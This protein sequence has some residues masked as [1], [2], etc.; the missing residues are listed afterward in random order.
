MPLPPCGHAIAVCE[1][2]GARPGPLIQ[3][4]IRAPTGKLT[5]ATLCRDCHAHLAPHLAGMV[6]R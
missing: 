2:C 3:L 4:S 6:R 5:V 1:I